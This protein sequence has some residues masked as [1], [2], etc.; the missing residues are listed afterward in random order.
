MEDPEGAG[1]FGGGPEGGSFES[2]IAGGRMTRERIEE[3]K[4][5]VQAAIG[6]DFSQGQM[7]WILYLDS[8]LDY[9]DEKLNGVTH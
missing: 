6:G 9:I 7:A 1:V 3:L 2:L 8:V 5:N 4:K